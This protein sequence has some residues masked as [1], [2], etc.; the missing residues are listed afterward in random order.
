MPHKKGRQIFS[1]PFFI[2]L[3]YAVSF[4]SLSSFCYAETLSSLLE[5]GPY[6]EEQSAVILEI[7]GKAGEEGI[8]EALILPRFEEGI[9][10]KVPFE[11]LKGVLEQEILYLKTSKKILLEAIDGI[12]PEE[13]PELWSR[14]AILLAT[15]ISENEIRILAKASV[16]RLHAFRNATTLYVSLLK[17]ELEKETSLKLVAALLGSSIPEQEFDSI[18][19]ILIIGRRR[20]IQPEEL[21]DRIIKELSAGTTI[22]TIKEKVLF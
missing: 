20:Y 2:V 5:N 4:L 12:K 14:A 16:S 1:V 6:T 8:P 18:L 7:F 3:S 21:A 22:E 17:W 11:R 15:G 13:H 19:N 10:K 9:A